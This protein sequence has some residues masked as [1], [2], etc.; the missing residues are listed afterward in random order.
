MSIPLRVLLLEDNPA[1]AELVVQELRVGG[2]E[3]DWQRVD[4]EEDFL[5]HLDTS[6]DVIL[7]DYHMPQWNALQA[8][9]L[10][11]EQGMDIPFIVVTGTLGDELAAE[12]MRRGAADFVIKD[13]MARL[14]L[15][16]QNALEQRR[17]RE[18]KTQ[19]EEDLQHRNQELETLFEIASVLA[20]PGEF[21]EKCR[22]ALG[23]LAQSVKAD[24]V[25]LRRLNPETGDLELVANA[26]SGTADAGA[27]RLADPGLRNPGKVVPRCLRTPVG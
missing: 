24:W 21:A 22:V 13:R 20:N 12:C 11:Q 9:R 15:A 10:M 8:L 19:A 23:R 14:P 1:D 18:E 17:I 25:T 6:L 5:T 7:A 2:F 27:R 3:P 26:G 16:V 4:T